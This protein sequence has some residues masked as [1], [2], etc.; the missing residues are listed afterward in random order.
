MRLP[1]DQP[2]IGWL[3]PTSRCAVALL[4]PAGPT[5]VTS[6]VPSAISLVTIDTYDGAPENAVA[7][8]DRRG[9]A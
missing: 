5:S 1:S 4:A 9:R 2:T 6:T 3:A 7:H 8:V